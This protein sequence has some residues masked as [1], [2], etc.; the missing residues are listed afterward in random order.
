MNI[1]YTAIEK[2]INKHFK[3]MGMHKEL[4][5]ILLDAQKKKKK[6]KFP[7]EF[8]EECFIDQHLISFH[9]FNTKS[10]KI[11]LY[12]P[13]GAFIYPPLKLHAKFAK[14]IAKKLNAHVILIQYPLCSEL[15]PDKTAI[16]IKKLIE[17][18]KYQEMI[19]IGDSAGACLSL[20]VLSALQKSFNN[21]VKKIIL[22][23]PWIDGKLNHPYIPLISDYD[24]ILDRTNCQQL[25]KKVYDPLFQNNLYLCPS[26]NDFKYE[27]KVLILSGGHEIVTPD[28][29]KWV[30]SQTILKVRHLIYSKMFH[31]FVLLPLKQSRHAL[32]QIDLFCNF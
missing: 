16:I 24:F 3:K 4:D 12:F 21:K 28:I 29:I 18:L 17:K 5:R 9:H 32:K 10:K 22:I 25:A 13:G 30:E 7:C 8:Y 23:S 6:K 1:L 31:C 26:N 19:L 27:C 15:T 20:L 14:K 11:F 2:I